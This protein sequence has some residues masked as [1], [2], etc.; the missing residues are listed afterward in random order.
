MRTYA[1]ELINRDTF[2]DLEFKVEDATQ[3]IIHFDDSMSEVD[4]PRVTEAYKDRILALGSI[5]NLLALPG[6]ETQIEDLIQ[7]AWKNPRW[8]NLSDEQKDFIEV[9]QKRRKI[10]RNMYQSWFFYIVLKNC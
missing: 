10:A 2:L 3:R 8:P 9:L 4:D 6:E 7:S 5:Y 1:P